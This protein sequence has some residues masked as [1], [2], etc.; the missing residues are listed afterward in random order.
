THA[1]EDYEADR[2]NRANSEIMRHIMRW[3]KALEMSQPAVETVASLGV[4]A[5]LLWAWHFRLSFNSFAA[6]NAGMVMLYPAFKSLSRIHLMMQKCLAST[7]K[8]FELLDRAPAI[9][10]DPQAKPLPKVR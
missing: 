9:S 5:A 1:R 3:R 6:L 8:V 10:D 7:T 2:F 4:A